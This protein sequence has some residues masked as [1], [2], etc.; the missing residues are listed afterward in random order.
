MIAEQSFHAAIETIY[1]AALAPAR[2]PA[3]LQ[4]IA[5]CFGDVGALLLYGRD[6]GGF[7]YIESLGLSGLIEPFF[8]DHGFRSSTRAGCG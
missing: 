4:S 7:G 1:D 5:D 2:W 6:D 3:A 8:A